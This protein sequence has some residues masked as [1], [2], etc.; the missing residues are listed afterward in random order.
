MSE[1][2][3]QPHSD[4]ELARLLEEQMKALRSSTSPSVPE[5]EEV[6]TSFEP[7]DTNDTA[8][9]ELFGALLDDSP[10]PAPTGSP[11]AVDERPNIDE[12]ALGLTQPIEY[13]SAQSEL[14][15]VVS[16]ESEEVILSSPNLL[17]SEGSDIEDVHAVTERVLQ[18]IDTQG[19]V[20]AT[21]IAATA[22]P[23]PVP[24]MFSVGPTQ[25]ND[26]FI[27]AL[28]VDPASSESPQHDQAA[29]F[30]RRVSKDES[31]FHSRPR[32]DDLVFGQDS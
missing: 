32:F 30:V 14:A 28:S 1:N 27:D 6:F 20:V 18:D 12:S 29:E 16:V 7:A 25:D 8:L 5:R 13:V 4:E 22:S 15:A 26:I 9:D 10:P 17:E 31:S 2:D 21:T 19:V 24:G 3:F 11:E 23:E